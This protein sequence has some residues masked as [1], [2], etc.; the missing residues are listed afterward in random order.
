MESAIEAVVPLF[1]N[2]QK[3][4]LTTHVNP[5]GD[6]LGSEI[7]LAEWLFAQGKNVSIINYSATPDFYVFLDPRKRITKFDET[8][9]PG[10]IANADVIVVMDTNQPDHL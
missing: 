9:D 5:D 2:H 6:A 8:R 7:A 1:R 10:T 3:F 4:V